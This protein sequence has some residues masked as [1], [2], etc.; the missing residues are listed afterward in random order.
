M[1]FVGVGGR[2]E[3]YSR[4]SGI[5]IVAGNRGGHALM[6]VTGEIES[7]CRDVRFHYLTSV[8]VTVIHCFPLVGDI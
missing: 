3:F 4:M 5:V 6:G 2:G 1:Q 7:V 8:H